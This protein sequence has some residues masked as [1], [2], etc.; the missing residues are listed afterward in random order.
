MVEGAIKFLSAESKDGLGWCRAVY[1]A[2]EVYRKSEDRIGLFLEEQMDENTAASCPMSQLHQLYRYWAEERGERP[3][4]MGKFERRLKDRGL[5]LVGTG[6]NAILYGY[7]IMRKT[8]QAPP[9]SSDVSFLAS[10][11][12]IPWGG[13]Y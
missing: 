9:P 5:N 7:G 8:V 13:N 10:E 12:G 4:A 11:G 6:S 2:A 3:L 1:E